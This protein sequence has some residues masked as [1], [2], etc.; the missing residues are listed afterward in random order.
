[1]PPDVARSAWDRPDETASGARPPAASVPPAAAI[2]RVV[3]RRAPPAPGRH[4]LAETALLLVVHDG[5]G[6]L[7]DLAGEIVALSDTAL[8]LLVSEL[9]DAPTLAAL[10]ERYRVAPDRLAADRAALL[11]DLVRRRA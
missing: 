1:M 10:A 6:R 2:R 4:A 7:I 3:T 11:A 8:A 5:S 9:E